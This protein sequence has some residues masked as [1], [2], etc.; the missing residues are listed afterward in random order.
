MA[1]KD[2]KIKDAPLV[3]TVQGTEKLP[4]SDGSGQPK[5]VTVN[6][7][8][9]SVKADIASLA[10]TVGSVSQSVSDE[11][12]RAKEAEAQLS[13]SISGEVNRAIWPRMS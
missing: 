1:E 9:K 11:V 8:N 13:S 7:I 12:A 10:E 5:A 2:I 4:C 6:Q 3:E